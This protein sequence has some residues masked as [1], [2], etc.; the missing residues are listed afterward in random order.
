MLFIIM[1]IFVYLQVR[2]WIHFYYQCLE[3]GIREHWRKLYWYGVFDEVIVFLQNS[4]LPTVKKYEKNTALNDFPHFF[5]SHKT[6]KG[7]LNSE[8]IYEV[9]VSSKMQTKNY[10]DFCP[11]YQ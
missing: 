8:W 11:K 3:I 10:K 7:Q 9:T 2:N 1:F 6:S 5:P 4:K